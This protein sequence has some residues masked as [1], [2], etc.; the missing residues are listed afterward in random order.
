MTKQ[1]WSDLRM[2]ALMLVSPHRLNRSNCHR[3]RRTWCWMT[4]ELRRACTWTGTQSPPGAGFARLYRPC[5]RKRVEERGRY[6]SPG[7]GESRRGEVITVGFKQIDSDRRGEAKHSSIMLR[8]GVVFIITNLASR[9]YVNLPG[10]SARA[11]TVN[12]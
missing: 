8:V 12:G 9:Y 2:F 3:R 11:S 6:E 4:R 1:Y 7:I 5:P 10:K